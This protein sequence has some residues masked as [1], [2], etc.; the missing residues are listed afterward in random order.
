M[1]A[2]PTHGA[3]IHFNQANSST[4]THVQVDGMF[5]AYDIES[6]V[7]LFFDGANSVGNNRS[8]PPT[9]GQAV[10]EITSTLREP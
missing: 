10:A 7:N 8:L 6:S 3:G 4:F 1:T 2:N 9:T 5:G